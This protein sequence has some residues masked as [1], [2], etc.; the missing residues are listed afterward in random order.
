M[1]VC[2]CVCIWLWWAS[3]AAWAFLVGGEW[4]YSPGVVCGPLTAVASPVVEHRLLGVQASVVEARGLRTCPSRALDHRLSPRLAPWHVG[5]SWIRDETHVSGIGRWILY[6]WATRAALC[7][8]LIS[9]S[10]TSALLVLSFYWLC[11]FSS[12]LRCKVVWDFSWGLS[13]WTS[14]LG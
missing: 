3:S 9:V 2:V 14:L 11:S 4:G 7:C 5:S 13:L 10:F 1:C 6:H 8:F 12:S